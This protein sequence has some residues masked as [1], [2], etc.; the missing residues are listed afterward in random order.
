VSEFDD[1][2]KRG[3]RALARLNA[4]DKKFNATWQSIGYDAV[5]VRRPVKRKPVKPGAKRRK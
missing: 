4:A 2:I 3:K 1:L 5:P